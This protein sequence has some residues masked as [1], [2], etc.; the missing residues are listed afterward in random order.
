M[1]IFSVEAETDNWPRVFRAINVLLDYGVTVLW[2]REETTISKK[3][4]PPG[5][6][7]IPLEGL[8][9]EGPD[10]ESLE[11]L[12]PLKES[13]LKDFLDSRRVPFIK[14]EL[15]DPVNVFSLKTSRVAL[16]EDS[17]CYNHAYVLSAAGFDVDWVSGR[18]VA[19]G[20]LEAF[21]IFMSGGGGGAKKANIE[22]ENLL[23]AGMG[24]EGAK[25]T[26]N[27]VKQG[28]AYLGC[29][30][31]SY[32]ASV[33]RD[34]FINWWHPAKP[35]MTMMN[36]EDLNINEF[37]DSGFKSP[38]QGE[39]TAK[40][41]E[42]TNPVVFGLPEYF[43]CTH[44]NGP[45]YNPI[46]GAVEQASSAT[47]VV[48][49]QDVS[50]EKFTP[51]ENYFKPN[52][53]NQDSIKETEIYKACKEGRSSI[54]QGFFGLGLVVLSGSHPEMTPYFLG[55]LDRDK[56]WISARILANIVLWAAAQS[57]LER[58]ETHEK[59]TSILMPIEPQT[60]FVKS[61]L[62]EIKKDANSFELKRLESLPTWLR[63]EFYSRSYGLT[64]T[65]MYEKTLNHI[66]YLCEEIENKFSVIDDLIH[67]LQTVKDAMT[68]KIQ[69]AK[70]DEK[71]A[72]MR[73]ENRVTETILRYYRALGVQRPPL[74]TQTEPRF[75][76]IHDLVR[77]AKSR[78]NRA[79]ER[80]AYLEKID[81]PNLS[82]REI[83]DNPFSNLSMSA[84]R[85]G[86]SLKLLYVYESKMDNLIS[87]WDLYIKNTA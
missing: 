51:F 23:L 84:N 26:S 46:E 24:V 67:K 44:W 11:K 81:A 32:I 54:N 83:T 19:N 6:F 42:P 72:M 12:A 1:N 66:P 75:L 65:Q 21:N 41:I 56:L 63:P 78:C 9:R 15:T 20:K 48:A 5:S 62:D 40:N 39:F 74:W 3:G 70:P 60:K 36:V 76:G 43:S 18:E 28:G 73:L 25:R 8:L 85:L 31:G 86:D 13:F 4:I 38:G 27:W 55:K 35:Y 87:M 17:G 64:P 82:Q 50:P 57:N 71:R 16:Y 37:S 77:S 79:K 53:A 58:K 68:K 45:V 2:N 49:F 14:S 52:D 22:R 33:V 69:T 80:G 7:I 29:C 47:P 59:I 61:I 10:S 34:R 30:G